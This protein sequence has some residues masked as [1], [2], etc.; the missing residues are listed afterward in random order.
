MN[1]HAERNQSIINSRQEKEERSA[2]KLP[3]RWNRPTMKEKF[4][5]PTKVNKFA[6]WRP[7]A[8]AAAA[9]SQDAL[10]R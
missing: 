2:L 5:Y 9:F 4:N 3:P 1:L 7:P 8:V 10:V 6:A